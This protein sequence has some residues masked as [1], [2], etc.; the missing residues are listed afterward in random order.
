ME[1]IVDQ[2]V[3]QRVEQVDDENDKYPSYLGVIPDYEHIKPHITGILKKAC[4]T[5]KDVGDITKYFTPN[6]NV[7]VKG[8]E[9]EV[10]DNEILRLYYFVSFHIDVNVIEGSDDK[11]TPKYMVIASRLD[12]KD[13]DAHDEH[14]EP[15]QAG[16]GKSED[17]ELFQSVIYYME[18]LTSNMKGNYIK[19]SDLDNDFISTAKEALTSNINS[20]KKKFVPGTTPTIM[21]SKYDISDK[22]DLNE[23]YK[24]IFDF[25]NT[26]YFK[27]KF[28][29]FM[30]EKTFYFEKTVDDK[31]IYR[32]EDY[33]GPLKDN[34]D[35]A[36]SRPRRLLRPRSAHFGGNNRKLKRK[37][38]NTMSL[39][40][41][42]QL[43]RN[44]GINMNSNK[45]VNALINNYIKHH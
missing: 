15:P 23:K 39:N 4:T 43:H 37:E 6:R 35:A 5:T 32:I 12:N 36:S 31:K 19:E 33:P 26:Y 18:G 44:A 29:G 41:L 25:N 24:K 27:V 9:L 34:A 10:Y 45:T 14:I 20:L 2:R 1:P 11:R 40:E 3:D 16:G 7:K 8:K 17:D 21:Y 30:Y 13:P 42:K 28:K 22:I 38:L